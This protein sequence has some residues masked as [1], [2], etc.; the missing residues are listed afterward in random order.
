MGVATTR[1]PYGLMP[2]QPTKKLA[3]WVELLGQLLSRKFVFKI[4]GPDPTTTPPLM[5]EISIVAFIVSLVS[6]GH[7]EIEYNRNNFPEFTETM[8][9]TYVDFTHLIRIKRNF[10]I[11]LHLIQ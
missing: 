5:P 4:F 8:S 1:A 2:Q 10:R 7:G 3:H 11:N 9:I 6:I